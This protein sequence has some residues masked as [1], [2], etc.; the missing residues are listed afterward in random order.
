MFEFSF[1]QPLGIMNSGMIQFMLLMVPVTASVVKYTDGVF[2]IDLRVPA[3]HRTDWEYYQSSRRTGRGTH[4][5]VFRNVDNGFRFNVETKAEGSQIAV[6]IDCVSQSSD[7]ET[8]IVLGQQRAILECSEDA[9]NNT[10]KCMWRTVPG[11]G[12]ASSDSS[13]LK[14][15]FNEN[16]LA[17]TSSQ[18]FPLEVSVAYD[19]T[20]NDC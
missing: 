11:P 19:A 12:L 14:I 13:P 18:A 1:S 20:D 5:H 17:L 8:P 9:K 6:S 15:S 2:N 4:G 3:I 7:E 10:N 16:K